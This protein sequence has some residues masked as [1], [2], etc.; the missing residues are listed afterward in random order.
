MPR[1]LI[2]DAHEWINEIPTVPTHSLAKLQPSQRSWDYLCISFVCELF[3]SL[4]IVTAHSSWVA[5]TLHLLINNSTSCHI[6]ILLYQKNHFFCFFNNQTKWVQ[7]RGK[8]TLLSLTLICYC[9]LVAKVQ[10]VRGST[11]C[12]YDHETPLL[13]DLADL[14]YYLGIALLQ[15]C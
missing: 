12:V 6:H 15:Y 13:V 3:L 4:M 7:Q 9:H 1:H 5:L 14:L 11:S 8:K 10:I 2:G